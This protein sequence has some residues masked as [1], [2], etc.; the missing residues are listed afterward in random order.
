[1]CCEEESTPLVVADMVTRYRALLDERGFDWGD[2]QASALAKAIMALKGWWDP[3]KMAT[4]LALFEDARRE[5]N[6]T[7]SVRDPAGLSELILGMLPDPLPTGLAVIH[8]DTVMVREPAPFAIAR[9]PVS[10]QVFVV[11]RDEAPPLALVEATVSVDQPDLEAEGLRL[12]AV[13]PVASGTVR[14]VSD[15][16]SRWRVWDERG[17]AWFPDN[18]LRKYDHHGRPFFHGNDLT[19][20][21]PIGKTVIEVGR[22]CE[23]RPTRVD[24]DVAAGSETVAKLAPTRLYDAAARGWYVADL[25][26]HMNYSG[27]LVCTPPDAARMQQGE[28]LHLMN[29]VAA[30]WNT[31][32]I[33][34]QEAFEH[35]AGQDLPWSDEDSI[36]RWGIEYRN[37][38]LGHFTALN[39]S[40]PPTRYQTGHRR[41]E[42]PQDWPPNAVAAAECR[43]LGATVGYTHPVLAPST[44]TASRAMCS[45]TPPRTARPRGSWWRMQRS[46]WSTPWISPG[47]TP[48]GGLSRLSSCIT[49]CW[50]VVCGWPRLRA[51]TRCCPI[52]GPCTRRCPIRLDGRVPTPTWA[53][54]PCR[55]RRGRTPSGQ[56]AR[57]PRTGLG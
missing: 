9:H 43:S 41:S 1:M 18:L 23:F 39:L 25:H 22:G 31:A 2:D 38:L 40:G 21:V 50:A 42:E 35:F 12:R 55:C 37:D 53:T 45:P 27:D 57:P 19:L 47:A 54:S 28:A 49:G 10:Y 8:R 48:S 11:G 33:Y 4:A 15:A 3:D 34:E 52:R 46:A 30:N 17:G 29:L 44:S 6:A 24:V 56:A 20:D 36:A 14:L 7:G 51:P 32:L 26:V 13:E 16:V 5:A